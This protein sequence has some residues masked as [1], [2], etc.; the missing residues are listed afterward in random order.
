FLFLNAGVFNLTN[1]QRRAT[2]QFALAFDTGLK[3]S[4][5]QEVT[6]TAAGVS[7]PTV[8]GRIDL[9][10]ARDDAGDCELTVKGNNNSLAR[11]WVYVGS[12]N[13]QPDRNADPVISKTNLRNLALNPGQEQ[14]YTCVPPGSGVRIGVDR[15]LDGVFD[16]TELDANTD[17]A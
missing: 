1:N 13:F 7:D 9:L 17:P 2:E 6:L 11:G 5:G 15:D 4:V 8:T 3:P 10:I 12:N 16:R 14:T